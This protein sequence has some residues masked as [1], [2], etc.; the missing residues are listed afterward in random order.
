[1]TKR[2][3]TRLQQFEEWCKDGHPDVTLRKLLIIAAG[4]I[5]N[6]TDGHPDEN[7]AELAAHLRRAAADL[8]CMPDETNGA[9]SPSAG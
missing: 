7:E 6:V 1:M 3:L 5:D 4:Y 2:R 8:F 9:A